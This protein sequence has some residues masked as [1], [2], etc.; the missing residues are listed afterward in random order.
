MENYINTYNFDFFKDGRSLRW[1]IRGDC[2]LNE[3]CDEFERRYGDK[4]TCAISIETEFL[5]KEPTLDL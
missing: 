3:A 1:S 4:V 2:T 5:E